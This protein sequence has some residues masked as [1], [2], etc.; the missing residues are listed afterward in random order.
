M[1][2]FWCN[3][4]AGSF[5][6]N[7]LTVP[8]WRDGR[9]PSGDE[10]AWAVV[11]A[12]DSTAAKAVITGA[13]H[14]SATIT[15][16]Q[17]SEVDAAWQPPP[18]FP[19][20]S[21]ATE[22]GYEAA[23]PTAQAEPPVAEV[24]PATVSLS[25]ATGTYALTAA[26]VDYSVDVPTVLTTGGLTQGSASS[27]VLYVVRLY[28]SSGSWTP[29]NFDSSFLDKYAAPITSI[30]L[31][32]EQR[33]TI[34]FLSDGT[35]LRTIH[36][37]VPALM[38]TQSITASTTAE[39]GRA[40]MVDNSAGLGRID[41]F[42]PVNPHVGD[43]FMTVDAAAVA[44]NGTAFQ[45]RVRFL[46]TGTNILQGDAGLI[47]NIT[48]NSKREGGMFIYAGPPTYWAFIKFV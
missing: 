36:D 32:P 10:V 7:T 46:G 45:H 5:V 48:M 25:S 28:N 15:F 31:A 12:A 11:D 3:F 29:L 21:Y 4:G 34:T 19:W 6:G 20:P 24:A 16:Y 26:T 39:V 17:V 41:I 2:R 9:G 33:R 44:G 23:D 37:T 18:R 35:S 14:P 42:P 30:E 27:G 38:P 40:L 22:N 13:F 43:Q 8:F 1:A 47:R